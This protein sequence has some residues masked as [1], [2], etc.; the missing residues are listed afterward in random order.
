[1][2]LKLR[3]AGGNSAGRSFSRRIR[4]RS[5][6]LDAVAKLAATTREFAGGFTYQVSHPDSLSAVIF[7]HT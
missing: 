5:G 4:G 2:Q 6:L 1:L 7:Q 3:R